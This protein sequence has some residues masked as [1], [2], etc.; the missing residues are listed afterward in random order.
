M[1]LVLLVADTNRVPG[2]AAAAPAYN[3]VLVVRQAVDDLALGLI[4]P[5]RTHHD[6]VLH[7]NF[8]TP[9]SYSLVR[10]T[11][12]TQCRGFTSDYSIGGKRAVIKGRKVLAARSG[13]G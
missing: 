11:L 5:L 7:D 9:P 4:A 13:K 12:R 8:A 6:G 10:K 3:H 1:E 2:V